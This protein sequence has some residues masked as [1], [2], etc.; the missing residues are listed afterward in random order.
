MGRI[1]KTLAWTF[2]PG[3]NMKGPIRAESSAER[4]A[5]EQAK[6]L[7]EQNRLL[8]K[9][10]QLAARAAKPARAGSQ[11]R[12]PGCGQP[13]EATPGGSAVPFVHMDTGVF[14]CGKVVG[15]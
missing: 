8:A 4:A 12:C 14:S 11:A 6:L 10:N 1:R 13:I 9:H 2:S 5:R 3:G 15:D 7:Q